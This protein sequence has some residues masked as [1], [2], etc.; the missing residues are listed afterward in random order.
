MAPATMDLKKDPKKLEILKNALAKT[1]KDVL[2]RS[3]L[4]ASQ[5][6]DRVA[7]TFW[8]A[9]VTTQGGGSKSKVPKAKFDTCRHCEERYDTTKNKKDSCTLT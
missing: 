4:E 7:K 9:L 1:P 8:D 2:E 5:N 6:D 3:I